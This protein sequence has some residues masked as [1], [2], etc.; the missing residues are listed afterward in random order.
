MFGDRA[1]DRR[2]EHLAQPSLGGGT[3]QSDDARRVA[4]FARATHQLSYDVLG[5]SEIDAR[6]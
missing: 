6:W 4:S 1:R 2:A 3:A 5:P